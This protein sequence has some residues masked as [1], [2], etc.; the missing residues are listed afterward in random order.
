MKKLT[1]NFASWHALLSIALA[2]I[3]FAPGTSAIATARL[4][5]A[6][7][8]T[9]VL[10]IESNVGDYQQL[11]ASVSLGIDVVVLDAKGDGLSQMAD[12]LAGRKNIS[13]IHL[14]SH[15]VKG[16]LDLGALTLDRETLL[17]RGADLK[18]MRAALRNDAEL[19]LYG[20]EVGQGP[21]GQEF[22]AM[23][24]SATGAQ[25]AASTNLT[26]ARELGG[27]WLLE[28]RTG[29]MRHAALAFPGYRAVLPTV[30]GTVAIPFGQLDSSFFTTKMVDGQ[31][32]TGTTNIASVV[33][34]FYF[35]NLTNT[36]YGQVTNYDLGGGAG[37]M[38]RF[39]DNN[40]SDYGP[41]AALIIKSQLNRLFGMS[42]FRMEDVNSWG[43]IYTATPYR[44]GTPGTGY[45]FTTGYSTSVV[46]FSLPLQFKNV[47]EIRIT[48]DGGMSGVGA[49]LWFEGFNTFVFIDPTINADLSN[50]AASAGTLVPTFAAGTTSYSF[51]VP[52]ATTSTTITPTVDTPGATVAVNGVTVASGAASGAIALNA[53]NNTIATVVTA[54]DG[55]TTKTYTTTVNRLPSTNANLSAL[56]LSSG[57]LA[58]AFA[59]GTTSYTASVS[60]ATS[61]LTVTPTVADSTATVTVNGVAVTSGNASGE[62]ALNVGNNTLTTLVTAQDGTTTKTYTVTVTRAS[63]SNANLSALSLSSGTLA[64]AFASGT[65]SYT[66][67]VG[68][69]T[70]SLTV[71]PTVADGT[72]S[73]TVNGAAVTSG[74]ASGAIALAV[75]NN[76]ITTTV[77]AQN[78]APSTYTVTV[79][80]AASANADLSALSLS[81]GTLAPAFASATTSYTASVGNATTSLTVTS[82]VLAGTSSVTVNGV[83]VI[84][85]NASG[86]IALAVGNNILTTVV[87]AQNGTT[88]KTYT[89]T[90]T[91]AASANADLSALSLSSGTMSPAFASATTGYT[92]SVGNATT[93]L[94]VTPTV[95]A[96]TSSVTVN[97]VA[98][99]S[100]NASGAIALNVGSNTITTVVTAQDGTT[101]KT[102]TV[103]I[104]RALPSANAD[105]SALSLSSGTLSPAFA[106]GTTSYTAGVGNATTSFTVTPTVADA[107]ASVTVNGVATASGNAS[108]AIALAVGAN[109]LTTVVTAQ[110]GTS[111][112]TYTV[113]VSRA[114]S[115]D[116]NLSALVLSG[117]S[118][119][120]AFAPSTTSYTV[121]VAAAT[122]S[123]NVTPTVNEPNA[124]VTV[125]GVS[126]ASSNASGAIAMNTGSNTVTV[127]VT[128]QNST[129][130]TY[131][132][133]VTR[134]V[135]TNNDLAALALSSGTLNPVFSAAQQ[136]YTATVPDASI[137]VTPT[138]ADSSASLTVNGVAT[139]SGTASASIALNIGSNVV[140]VQVTAQG[141]A[142]KSYTVNVT[143]SRP[144]TATGTSPTGGGSVSASLAGPAG[145]GFDRAAFIPL[146]G[147]AGSPPAGGTAGYG[148][149]QGLFDVIVG[150]CPNGAAVAITLT[151]PQSFPTG[152]VYMK[153]GPTPSQSAP[154]WYPFAGATITGNTVTV[155]LTDGNLGDDDLT[156]NGTIAD[157]GG[158]ALALAFGGG[159]TGIP[160]LSQWGVMLLSLMLAAAAGLS[161]RRAHRS[162]RGR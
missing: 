87:T 45:T 62:I 76:I 127:S 75:G 46:Q 134:A 9:G 109:T 104:T 65:T 71:T 152:A 27:D 41:V 91:R 73:V 58:P 120:P 29:A 11:A 25:V 159:A 77:T 146:T 68:N 162:G 129:T 70:T 93:S 79:T 57:T 154:H 105:L 30:A 51:S 18:R 156:M 137:T 138:L 15:G 2:W 143:R 78:G 37:S 90:V 42:S 124:T 113:T 133:T 17:E 4:P 114:G 115:G 48:S 151:Y 32:G 33:Y 84:S 28:S 19:F 97:G 92:A 145:C 81:S 135:S 36:A 94:T 89:V 141:G 144:T 8:P 82:T 44:N 6:L 39:Y 61:T 1:R 60:N 86:A 38:M 148:F 153:Y 117:G 125:N 88:T 149:S 13:A 139:S 123:I 80:R 66:A 26:G 157:P 53:G 35:A 119:S 72:A 158:V 128:A 24:A 21:E 34:E 64:P 12:A 99:T 111:T 63:S 132:V 96:G 161:A 22:V 102:Y 112:K 98:T 52:F 116:A 67:S 95:A 49:K 83:A 106:S 100:G 131:T 150:G 160:T 7:Q 10:F 108:G 147:G 107:T 47:D 54:T 59:A 69:A 118:L 20:C 50:L 55:S 122:A 103:T 85:G 14:I 126:V 56:A 142:S 43:A 23:L 121:S 31:A 140:T 5:S 101:T 110:N 155:V 130:K 3:L 74:N 136:S 40:T 16:A